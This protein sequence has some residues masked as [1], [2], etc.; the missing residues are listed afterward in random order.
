MVLPNSN[1]RC[2]RV[3]GRMELFK[4]AIKP[5]MIMIKIHQTSS[6]TIITTNI[7]CIVH[8]DN[9]IQRLDVIF[10]NFN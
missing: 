4:D 6:K 3:I 7:V 1:Q 9:C 10:K 8:A 5:I 2:I